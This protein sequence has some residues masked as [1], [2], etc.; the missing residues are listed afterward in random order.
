MGTRIVEA[1]EFAKQ[2]KKKAN[3]DESTL[4]AGLYD[5]TFGLA[6][7]PMTPFACVFAGKFV[8]HRRSICMVCIKVALTHYF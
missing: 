7:D 3:A 8:R 4:E 2:M 6:G 1:K 5:F